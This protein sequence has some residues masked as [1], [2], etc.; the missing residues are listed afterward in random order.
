MERGVF[1]G[2][3]VVLDEPLEPGNES[4]AQ[5]GAVRLVSRVTEVDPAAKRPSAACGATSLDVLPGTSCSLVDRPGWGRGFVDQEGS[6][7]RREK[8]RVT[9]FL[10]STAST[11]QR[12]DWPETRNLGV[13]LSI[14]RSERLAETL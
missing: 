10:E 7:G 4:L 3:V 6:F 5:V 12:T 14:E 9:V 1:P 2:K 11:A 13:K 8:E